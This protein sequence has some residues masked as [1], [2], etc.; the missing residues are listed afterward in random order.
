MIDMYKELRE[1]VEEMEKSNQTD[2]REIFRVLRLLVSEE[3]KPK[4]K[5]GFDTGVN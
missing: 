4:E 2:H 1:K 5:L 3:N